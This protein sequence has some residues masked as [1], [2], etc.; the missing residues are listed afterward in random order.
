MEIDLVFLEWQREGQGLHYTEES[1]ELER[2]TFHGGTTF[3]AII[4]LDE[5]QEAELKETLITGVRPVFYLCQS[6]P[7]QQRPVAGL[8]GSEGRA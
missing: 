8:C 4:E 7:Q 1:V 2:G 6:S 5:S 3:E